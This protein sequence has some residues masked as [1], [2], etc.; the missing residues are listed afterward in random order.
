MDEIG[1]G[2]RPVESIGLE[3]LV[4][5]N[6]EIAALVRCG[7]PLE[8]GL[9]DAG[10]D[11]PGRLGRITST[12]AARMSH[13]ESLGQALEAER[14]A[15]PPLY[16]AIV[17]AG[18]RAGRL[19]AALE[20]LATYARGYLE[21]RQSIGLALAYP[22]M[23]AV[24]AYFL[25]LGF[26]TVIMP[27]FLTALDMFRLPVTAPV[28]W[29]G[30]V[31]DL[32]PYWWPIG[33]IVF[34]AVIFAWVRSGKS[35]Q[36]QGGGWSLIGVIPWLKSLLADYRS[37]NFTQLLALLI[38]HRVALPEALE[39]AGAASGDSRL[40]RDTAE[41]SEALKRGDSA[42]SVFANRA[43][44]ITPLVRWLLVAGQSQTALVDSLRNIS[45]TY[46]RRANYR[47]ERFQVLV[48]IVLMFVL[49]TAT[50]LLYGLTLFFPLVNLLNG[51]SLH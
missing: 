26:V 25:F 6:D 43:F 34:F 7:I 4:A 38:E 14:R 42:K 28:R 46:R 51:L 15:I 30:T 29:L 1:A 8:R 12:L 20:G 3:Q 19:P 47:A 50:T 36:F 22:L 31:G 32:T 16:C 13:G 21:A 24:L 5:L 33:P 18:L 2:Q 45:S 48:P 39:L 27:R 10:R 49:G 35:L 9:L 37:A 41:L 17:E 40:M 23:V 44:A 11:L